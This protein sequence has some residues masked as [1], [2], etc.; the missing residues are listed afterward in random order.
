VVRTET[1]VNGG[2]SGSGSLGGGGGGNGGASS[3]KGMQG[4]IFAR[5]DGASCQD[6]PGIL[7]EESVTKARKWNTDIPNILPHERV[8]PIQIGSELFRLSG[9][10]I[11]SDGMYGKGKGMGKEPRLTN[12]EH[13]HTFP[14]FFN[15]SCS[16]RKTTAM[17]QTPY[18][19]Y[20]STAIP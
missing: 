6:P 15:A 3:S 7:R 18:E 10:S 4:G 1:M 17:I 16:K 19:P 12:L 8:F 11:S 9:A 13:P 20:T 14:S 2:G 5:E